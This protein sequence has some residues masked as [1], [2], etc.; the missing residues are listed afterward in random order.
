MHWTIKNFRNTCQPSSS[1]HVQEKRESNLNNNLAFIA[2]V[3]QNI[4][5]AIIILKPVDDLDYFF[6]SAINELD[7]KYKI[8]EESSIRVISRKNE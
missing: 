8:L 5:Q 6:S 4:H 3:L 7:R 2:G 1:T